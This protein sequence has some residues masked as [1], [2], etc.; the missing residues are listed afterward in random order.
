MQA[1]CLA[2]SLAEPVRSSS[3]DRKQDAMSFM[4]ENW[5]QNQG[6]GKVSRIGRAAGKPNRPGL[7]PF[8]LPNSPTCPKPAFRT[9]GLGSGRS[10]S[11]LYQKESRGQGGDMHSF[12]QCTFIC[13]MLMKHPLCPRC[14]ARPW[15]YRNK[16]KWMLLPALWG[17]YIWHSSWAHMTGL[18]GPGKSCWEVKVGWP[19]KGIPFY[20]R[21]EGLR[22][23][24]TPRNVS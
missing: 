13:L 7:V 14:W 8:L 18:L 11:G 10:S 12:I 6:P 3:R 21:L 2:K 4:A 19:R 17:A 23:L 16:Q 22:P 5:G 15:P 9:Q 20:R 24:Q 1:S